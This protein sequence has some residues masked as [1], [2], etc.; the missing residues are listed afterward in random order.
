[1]ILWIYFPRDIN[2]WITVSFVEEHILR[3]CFPTTKT[4]TILF[5][6]FC[7]SWAGGVFQKPILFF[8]M[9]ITFGPF[10]KF[11]NVNYIS[12][13]ENFQH[14]GIPRRL[15]RWWL[16]WVGHTLIF[17]AILF[18]LIFF[19]TLC[20]GGRLYLGALY[21][22]SFIWWVC[23]RK[24]PEKILLI[25]GFLSAILSAILLILISSN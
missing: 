19:I 8:E 24:R 4:D 12:W 17:L 1:M 10:Q 20:F 21:C 3:V 13:V 9:F 5:M 22:F 23:F 6:N 25:K 18:I 7:N 2:D 14:L 15:L 16:D 11:R